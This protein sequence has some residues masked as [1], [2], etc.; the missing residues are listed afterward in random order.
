MTKPSLTVTFEESLT[1]E[2]GVTGVPSQW[3]RLDSPG[4][5]DEYVTRQRTHVPFGPCSR[6][7]LFG[8][9]GLPRVVRRGAM[10]PRGRRVGG[11]TLPSPWTSEGAGPDSP[12]PPPRNLRVIFPLDGKWGRLVLVASH[13]R[14]LEGPRTSTALRGATGSGPCSNVAPAPGPRKRYLC[15]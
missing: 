3:D 14:A 8:T 5:V 11:K 10:W 6:T 4:S 15:L 2:S 7:V 1:L 12:G 9:L 13:P